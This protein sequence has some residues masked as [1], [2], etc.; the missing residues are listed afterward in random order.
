MLM[1]LSTIPYEFMV[2]AVSSVD[3]QSNS[4]CRAR[5]GDSSLCFALFLHEGCVTKM[6]GETS[7]M[8]RSSGAAQ[9]QPGSTRL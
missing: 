9:G 5:L 8:P 3:S 1:D 7:I 6:I 2:E 4:S